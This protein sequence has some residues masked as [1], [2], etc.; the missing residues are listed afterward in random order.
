M[1]FFSMK[2]EIKKHINPSGRFI[3]YIRNRKIT[4]IEVK[5][6]ATFSLNSLQK[7]KSSFADRV[8]D[9]IVIYEGDYKIE[10]N[11]TYV[12]IFAIDWYL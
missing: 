2:K 7:L 3:F 6:S 4:P 11:I 5:S 12:P 8:K 9:G 10:N 1:I